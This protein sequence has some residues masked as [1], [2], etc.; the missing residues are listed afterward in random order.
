MEYPVRVERSMRVSPGVKRL[1]E[2]V[3][4]FENKHGLNVDW[5]D[6]LEN[7]YL[8]GDARRSGADCQ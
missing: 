2:K 1:V 8:W 3:V 5:A 4:R 7:K 6:S